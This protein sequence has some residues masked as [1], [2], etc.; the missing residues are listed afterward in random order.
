M[1]KKNGKSKPMKK[2]KC[3]CCGNRVDIDTND[4]E[5]VGGA[6]IAVCPICFGDIMLKK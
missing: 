6:K 1:L 3:S 4:I 5:E 2:V